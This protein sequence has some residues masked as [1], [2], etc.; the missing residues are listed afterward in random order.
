LIAIEKVS[1]VVVI[2]VGGGLNCVTSYKLTTFQWSSLPHSKQ[3]KL[4]RFDG[5]SKQQKN[6][7][8]SWLGRERGVN[9]GGV[10]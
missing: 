8:Q 4:I 2:V 1:F 7:T 5:C 3:H 9:L 6:R 10:E